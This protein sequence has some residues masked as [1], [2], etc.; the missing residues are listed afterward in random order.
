MDGFEKDVY[1]E[2]IPKVRL[3]LGADYKLDSNDKKSVSLSIP[4]YLEDIRTLL[5]QGYI[6]IGLNYDRQTKI[7]SMVF[8]KQVNK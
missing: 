3:S 4:Q 2:E 6:G 1:E 5:G 8:Q 7:Y